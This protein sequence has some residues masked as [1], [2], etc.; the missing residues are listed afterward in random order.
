MQNSETVQNLLPA[1]CLVIRD[2]EAKVVGDL[3][4]LRNGEKIPADLRL[5]AV[6]ELKVD[7][8]SLTGESEPQ[9]RT[10]DKG[11]NNP[12]EANNLAFYGTL[13]VNGEGYGIVIRTGDR[14]VLGSIAN[15]TVSETKRES[16]LANEIDFFVKKTATIA[17]FFSILF[18]IIGLVRDQGKN[19]SGNL[20]FAIGVLV[21]FVP[22]GLPATVTVRTAESR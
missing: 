7:N 3:V 12:L 14:T 18:L 10:L 17:G 20:G 8:S 19:I 16:Q 22:Q 5:V 21:A 15:L 6:T 9:E 11:N 2:G 13:V 4:S 1:N